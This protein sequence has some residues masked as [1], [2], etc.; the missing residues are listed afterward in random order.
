MVVHFKIHTIEELFIILRC[1][2]KLFSTFF[3]ELIN[4]TDKLIIV[5][6]DHVGKSREYSMGASPHT[7]DFEDESEDYPR[8][9]FLSHAGDDIECF[10]WSHVGDNIGCPGSSCLHGCLFFMVG[11][12]EEGAERWGGSWWWQREDG[13]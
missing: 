5:S 10:S 3:N 6:D 4:L 9:F 12:A 13:S 8:C 11:R 1:G 2:M 7:F